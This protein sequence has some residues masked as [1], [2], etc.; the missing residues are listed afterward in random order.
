[1]KR[2]R[3][4]EHE[5][6]KLKKLVAERDGGAL[7]AIGGGA[8]LERHLTQDAAQGDDRELLR[9]ELDEGWPSA[10]DPLPR[11]P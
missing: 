1:V 6:L 9:L 3:Q 5:N 2:L 11:T 8:L 7:Y 10:S 4:L